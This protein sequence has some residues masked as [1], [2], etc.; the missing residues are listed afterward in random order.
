M[1]VEVEEEVEEEVWWRREGVPG[2]SA[3]SRLFAKIILRRA[4]RWPS[5]YGSRAGM[6]LCET[7]RTTKEWSLPRLSG[8]GRLSWLFWSQR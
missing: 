1:E 6:S 7:S 5:E 2:S 4:G 8:R 3:M